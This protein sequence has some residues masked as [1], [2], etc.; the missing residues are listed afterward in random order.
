[1]KDNF[2]T[3]KKL[4]PI[5]EVFPNQFNP[6]VQ[7]KEMIE[8]GKKSVEELGFLMP[9]LVRE[10]PIRDSEGNELNNFIY[11]ILDGEH[12]WRYCKELN[13]T[14]IPVESLGKVSDDLARFLTVHINNLRGKDDILKRAELLKSFDENQLALL[15]FDRNQIDEEM[16]LLNFDFSQYEKVNI[17]DQETLDKLCIPLRKMEE[18]KIL[19]DKV[20]RDIKIKELNH[21]IIQYDNVLFAFRKLVEKKKLKVCEE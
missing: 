11:E 17:E 12:R 20:N 10:K 7:T 6:N 16:K 14:E 1:M 8:K 4:V 3:T 19:L 13:Y 21:L 15:P 9:I 5:N 2:P 18:I